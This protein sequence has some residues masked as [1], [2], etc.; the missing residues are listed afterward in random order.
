MS[1]LYFFSLFKKQLREKLMT[2]RYTA[3]RNKSAKP[4]NEKWKCLISKDFVSGILPPPM[5][6]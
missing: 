5:T 6:Q 2:A 3:I 4:F 1:N